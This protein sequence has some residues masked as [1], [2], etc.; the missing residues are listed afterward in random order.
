MMKKYE[1]LQIEVQDVQ[2]DVITSSQ[3]GSENDWGIG[4][5][6]FEAGVN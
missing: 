4:E 6:P 2:D 5:V 3:E 1:L